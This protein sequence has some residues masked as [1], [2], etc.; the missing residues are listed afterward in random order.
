MYDM[1][2]DEAVAYLHKAIDAAGYVCH[3]GTGITRR[4]PVILA[5]ILQ[6]PSICGAT[7]A[8]LSNLLVVPV[9]G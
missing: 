6:L 7:R 1:K 2:L 3:H 5:C 9:W 8:A 4:C